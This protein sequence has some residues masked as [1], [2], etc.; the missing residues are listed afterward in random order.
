M[1]RDEALA[2]SDA[3][4]ERGQSHTVVVGVRDGYMPRENYYVNVTPVLTFSPT[5][6]SGL[7][8]LA[9]H[10]GYG[11]AYINGSFTFTGAE[12]G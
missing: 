7:Q 12:R 8:R 6:I 3:L 2:I 11:I 5:D 1:T 9:D 4:A 10:L